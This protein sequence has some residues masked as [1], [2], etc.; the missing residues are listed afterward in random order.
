MILRSLAIK[1]YRSLED[2]KLDKLDRF[3][4]LIGRNNSGKSSVFGALQL[5]NGV[6]NRAPFQWY[7]VLTEL[8]MRRSLEIHLTFDLTQRDREEFLNLIYSTP[9]LQRRRDEAL[10]SP[11]MRQIEYV[12]KAPAGRPDYLHPH[13]IRVLA[14]D[15][16]WAVV[17]R[18][19]NVDVVANPSSQIVDLGIIRE[20]Y[21]GYVLNSHLLDVG[22]ASV[23]D[24]SLATQI[25]LQQG[26]AG[27]ETMWVWTKL[28]EYLRNAF[29]FDPF[30]HS[31]E[32]AA[33]QQ[34]PELAQDGSNLAQVLHT[35]NSNDRQTFQEIERFVQAAL[36]DVGVLQTPLE[37][38]STRISF[39]RPAGGY[40]VWLHD[41]GGGIEQLLMAATV[42]LTTGDES[43][44][45][46]EEPESH[47]HAGAQR[48]LM[49]QLYSGDRQ[50]FISTHSPTFVNISR[51]RSLYR[52]VYSNERTK[53]DR[54][55]DA[56]ALGAAL[57][58]IGARNSDVLLSDAV[59]FVEGPSDRD[60]LR[61]WSET[62]GTSLAESNVAVLPMGG[63]EYAEGKAR[64]RGGILEGIS[65]KAPV[66]HL[67]V[68]DRDERSRAEIEKLQRDLG[69]KVVLLEMRELENYLVV[70]RAILEAVR[71]KHSD[72]ASALERIDNTSEAEI[73]KLVKT[74][75]ESLYGVVLLKRIRTG[76]EG[77]KGGLMPRD[78]AASLA[79]R[80]RRVDLPKTLRGKI[81]SRLNEH[82]AAI[83]V[84]Q[85]V[86]SERQAL[87]SEWTDPEK[88]LELAPGE[89]VLSAVFKHLGSEYKKTKD[90][91]RIAQHMHADEIA[92]E[93]KRLLKKAVSLP[94]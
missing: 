62:L 7:R 28:A 6:V 90:A 83:D 1:N 93:I 82:L 11:L 17:Q 29:F 32:S 30:R 15:G 84:D 12:F 59:L 22:M 14:E 38:T 75:A 60:V 76:L 40:E 2:V 64:V 87:D 72:N 3:N 31:I 85:L 58:D 4:V 52:V 88:H 53:I 66:P 80:A 42:L 78:M 26:N 91:V 77:L 25:D 46:L 89:E 92:P 41:M 16:Q 56:Q 63:G 61:V 10:N 47:L 73:E 9:D 68:L 5:V 70:P 43:T 19:L 23:R 55:N 36:P 74:N 34:T 54:V 27:P 79:P 67:F 51:P 35:I 13:E 48:F 8:D 20:R 39:R 37:G 57:E 71:S 44:L 45:F 18:I 81:K 21:S 49:E 69:E 24:S 33:A 86:L 50:V 65:E 94:D